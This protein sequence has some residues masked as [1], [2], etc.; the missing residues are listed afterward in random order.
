MLQQKVYDELMNKKI[1][2]SEYIKLNKPE[3]AICHILHHLRQICHHPLCQNSY[4]ML[5]Q[6]QLS[7]PK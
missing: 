3:G 6:L 7:V 4:I 5:K 2:Q 1:S